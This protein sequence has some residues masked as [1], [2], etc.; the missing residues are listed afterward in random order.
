[1][2]SS[3]LVSN[4][5]KRKSKFFSCVRT[6]KKESLSRLNFLTE[7]ANETF[8]YP[9]SKQTE[10]RTVCIITDSC[11]CGVTHLKIIITPQRKVYETRLW[12]VNAIIFF[13]RFETSVTLVPRLSSG[14]VY[15][16]QL[17]NW[18]GPAIKNKRGKRNV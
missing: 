3:E 13:P 9:L 10:R 8:N 6:Q 18:T 17:G 4:R 1:M 2:N 15:R 16:Y 7:S 12:R 11:C 14:A 5:V